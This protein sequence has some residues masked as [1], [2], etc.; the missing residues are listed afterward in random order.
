MS[1]PQRYPTLWYG[2]GRGRGDGNTLTMEADPWSR[3]HA[4]ANQPLCKVTP[5]PNTILDFLQRSPDCQKFCASIRGANI[6]RYLG[7]NPMS[8]VQQ[9]AYTVICPVDDSPGLDKFMK[10]AT[11][12]CYNAFTMAMRHI[13]K[14]LVTESKV[15]TYWQ[16]SIQSEAIERPA[17]IKFQHDGYRFTIG[18]EHYEVLETVKTTNG[19]I[20]KIRGVLGN[21]SPRTLDID[22]VPNH[23]T[24]IDRQPHRFQP[25]PRVVPYMRPV[26]NYL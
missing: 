13:S 3:W 8:G 18:E 16:L 1:R 17:H 5:E 19:I 14:T 7:S 9:T 11:T 21:G 23:V 6:E 10:S 24:S 25:K 15:K 4:P 2:P 22:A 12:N 20:Y 26:V